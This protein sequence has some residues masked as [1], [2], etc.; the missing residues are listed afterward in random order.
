MTDTCVTV[1]KRRGR[2]RI[3]SKS[4]PY[5]NTGR[6]VPL[7]S[8]AREFVS[9]VR[10]YFSKE[11]INNGPLIP[12]K[13]VVDRTSAALQIDK[14]TVVNIGKEKKQCEE[15]GGKLQTPNKKIRLPKRVTGLD[16]FQQDAIRRHIYSYITRKEYPTLKKLHV[17]LREDELFLGS[18]SSLALV[19]KRLGFKYKKLGKR[20]CLMERTDIVA[21]RCRFFR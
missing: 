10:D 16:A 18:K 19:I 7:R 11:K 2:P 12:V 6:G 4:E 8:Q 1:N 3:H 13:Q 14:S 5:R 20:K 9:R 15:S 17:S 21:W